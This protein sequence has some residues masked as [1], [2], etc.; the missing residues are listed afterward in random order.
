MTSLG[1]QFLW[2]DAPPDNTL[3]LE[4]CVGN[5]VTLNSKVERCTIS[6]AINFADSRDAICCRSVRPVRWDWQVSGM[7]ADKQRGSRGKCDTSP[8]RV[9]FVRLPTEGHVQGQEMTRAHFK[10][11][12][13]RHAETRSVSEGLQTKQF[14]RHPSLTRRVTKGFE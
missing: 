11:P 10:T 1:G 4:Q 8:I 13:A 9:S 6:A 12:L 5:V 7:H 3:R 14:Q 2:Q